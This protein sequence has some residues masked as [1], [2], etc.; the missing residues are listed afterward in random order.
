MKN[1]QFT[2]TFTHFPC[3]YFAMRY[4]YE[5]IPE[6]RSI[7]VL[8]INLIKSESYRLRGFV[9]T[10]L[11]LGFD[12][13]FKV[14]IVFVC[15]KFFELGD[16][17]YI[18][19][20]GTC[21]CHWSIEEVICEAL[22]LAIDCSAHTCPLIPFIACSWIRIASYRAFRALSLMSEG[23]AVMNRLMYTWWS[24]SIESITAHSSIHW[25][26]IASF[27]SAPISSP[28]LD[29]SSAIWLSEKS[30]SSAHIL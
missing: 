29:T 4:L 17:H 19:L 28:V 16:F 1:L 11:Y 21:D 25:F 12:I 14:E 5:F 18:A 3:L 20:E 15:E 27:I 13:R 30:A 9:F 10:S 8:Y 2:F 23:S 6:L 26:I 24:S 7:C 22:A